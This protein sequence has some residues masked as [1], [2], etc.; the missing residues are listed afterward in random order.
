MKIDFS[1]AKV[2]DEVFVSMW[3]KC[4]ISRVEVIG[5]LPLKIEG[6]CGHE[7]FTINGL[8]FENDQ[9]PTLFHSFSEFQKYW[10]EY[11]EEKERNYYTPVE[12]EAC[13]YNMHLRILL[14]SQ[15][16]ERA[17]R[18]LLKLACTCGASK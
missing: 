12:C 16:N 6:S 10:K 11:E 9:H 1:D 7:Y 18:Y 2:G 14:D 13:S 4:K 5:E 15:V 3:G 8:L 17:L